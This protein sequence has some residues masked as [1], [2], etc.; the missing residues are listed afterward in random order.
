[1]FLEAIA[2]NESGNNYRKVNNLGYLGKYQF[3]RETLKRT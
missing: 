2:I 1:M 3:G